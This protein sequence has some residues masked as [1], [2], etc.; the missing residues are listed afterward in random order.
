MKHFILFSLPLLLPTFAFVYLPGMPAFGEDAPL[1]V[2]PDLPK[3]QETVRALVVQTREQSFSKPPTSSIERIEFLAI[4]RENHLVPPDKFGHNRTVY[5]VH[6]IA[7]AEW[8]KASL[9]YLMVLLPEDDGFKP[10][11]VYS[12]GGS[13]RGIRYELVELDDGEY[14]PTGTVP[15]RTILIEDHSSGNQSSERRLLLYRYDPARGVF[16]DIL[17]EIIEF[18]GSFSGPYEAFESTYEFRRRDNAP[19][20]PWLKD[21]VVATGWFARALRDTYSRTEPE[22]EQRVSVFTWNGTRYEGRLDIPIQA[23]AFWK[24][25]EGFG[26]PV[27][28]NVTPEAPSGGEQ[29]PPS[30]LSA[31]D[32]AAMRSEMDVNEWR[33]WEAEAFVEKYG[34][35]AVP[36]LIGMLQEKDVSPSAK[37]KAA[38]YLGKFRQ[39]SAIKP[40]IALIESPLPE[41]IG[42]QEKPRLYG[43]LLGLGFIGSDEALDYLKKLASDDYWLK[44]P[45]R[46]RMPHTKMNEEQTRR[47]L[48]TMTINSIGV[49]GNDKAIETLEELKRG[50]ASDMADKVGKSIDHARRRQKGLLPFMPE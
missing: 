42:T 40:I 20:R 3:L 31:A 25:L 22:L 9:H 8:W 27:G 37:G 4:Q 30:A 24:K 15:L 38:F 46:P 50:A 1:P 2:E 10:L 32:K 19:S 29:H 18:T 21:I 41:E 35:D 36:V 6:A 7:H 13:G 47:E 16:Y 45:E 34:A 44:R 5:V 49:A 12:G 43:A 28:K 23:E 48:R 33:E 39:P 11:L 17:D 14:F 26:R